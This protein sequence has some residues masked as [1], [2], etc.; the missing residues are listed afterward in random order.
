MNQNLKQAIKDT[1]EENNF[2]MENRLLKERIHIFSGK[3]ESNMKQIFRGEIPDKT[4]I[5]KDFLKRAKHLFCIFAS[6]LVVICF[7]YS[8]LLERKNNYPFFQ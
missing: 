2:K 3:H 6:F 4:G 8:F 5:S 1:I 7:L